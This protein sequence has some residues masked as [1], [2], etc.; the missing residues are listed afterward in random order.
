MLSV[1]YSGMEHRTFGWLT[2]DELERASWKA[3]ILKYLRYIPEV[4]P[5]GTE[6]SHKNLS[7]RP[8]LEVVIVIAVVVVA[9]AAESMQQKM[10]IQ[11]ERLFNS[12]Q[13]SLLVPSP[14]P[15]TIPPSLLFHDKVAAFMRI[16]LML[17]AF[18]SEHGRLFRKLCNYVSS[19]VVG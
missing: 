14:T 1:T 15:N 3:T 13:N 10:S 8:V 12:S 7:W 5:R 16:E 6:K 17:K 18:F 19:A 11:H 9:A 4:A 2:Q